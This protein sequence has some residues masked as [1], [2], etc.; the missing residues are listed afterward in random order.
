M[1]EA[2]CDRREPPGV[3]ADASLAAGLS[4]LTRSDVRSGSPAAHAAAERATASLG[5]RRARSEVIAATG[6][7]PRRGGPCARRAAVEGADSGLSGAPVDQAAP[8]A[9][10]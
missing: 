2:V 4:P 9:H 1:S 7:P 8:G 5:P 6:R 10:R 3:P